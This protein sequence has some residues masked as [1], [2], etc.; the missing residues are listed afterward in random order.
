MS[1]DRGDAPFF[2]ICTE[3]TDRENTIRRTIE[4]IA[5]QTYRNFEYIIINNQSD[6]RSD[7]VIKEALR[8]FPFSDVVI[9]YY[10]T[11]KKL[12]DIESWN[13]PLMY[14][15]G[16]YIVV[17]EG[18]DWFAPDHL[19]KAAQVLTA[20]KNIGLYVSGRGDL[21]AESNCVGYGGVQKRVSNHI[22]VKQFIEFSFAPPPSEAIFLR[23]GNKGPFLYDSDKYIFAAEY[24]LY[25]DILS[26][27]FDGYI[28]LDAG[29]VF[30]GRSSYVR[31]LFHVRD[32]YTMLEQCRSQRY[33]SRNGYR[34]ARMK[35]LRVSTTIL[36]G[37]IVNMSI[38]RAFLA[39]FLKEVFFL[40]TG[41]PLWFLLR[42]IIVKIPRRFRDIR[43][44]LNYR[45]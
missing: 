25:Y 17:C 40:R 18:D 5:R 32:A 31:R 14:A 9:K 12:A 30:R 27:G 22:L 1:I 39:H 42:D 29:T 41:R 36:A 15:R 19:E 34:E 43:D 20:H 26:Q 4:S 38:E 7:E 24:G 28:N 11:Q 21:S 16:T 35:L 13:A 45:N 10:T 3:V 6:D 2:S 44:R 33:Y 37:Q 8:E 23:V